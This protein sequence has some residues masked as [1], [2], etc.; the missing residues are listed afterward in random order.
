MPKFLSFI[1]QKGGTG[2]STLTKATA[3]YLNEH[4]INCVVV[5][6]DYPQHSLFNQR[7]R[8][9]SRLS[10]NSSSLPSV[11]ELKGIGVRPYPIDASNVETSAIRLTAL[12]T[13]KAVDITLIDLP[14]TLNVEGIRQIVK[15]LDLAIIPCEMENMSVQ[16]ALD[17]VDIL[18]EFR[19]DLRVSFLWSRLDRNHSEVGR[20][21]I[22]EIVRRR[23]PLIHIYEFIAYKN[24]DFREVTTIGFAPSVMGP[25]VDELLQF[26]ESP[27]NVLIN[28]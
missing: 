16:A 27:V 20:K 17:T 22:E 3:A 15:Q 9:L 23:N 4:G 14:G 2:K 12:R 28:S 11:D 10:A 6:S 19:P 25:L 24:R 18:Y 5:D 13:S 8:D 1:C 7:Y 21:G 26:L